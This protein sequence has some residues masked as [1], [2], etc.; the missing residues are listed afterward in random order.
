MGIFLEPI[1]LPD[2]VGTSPEGLTV[3]QM[4]EDAEALAVLAAPCI[5]A[6]DFTQQAAVKA[7]LRGAILRWNDSG[8][9][10]LVSET[11][12]PFG[13]TL[14]TRQ[15]RRTMFWPT[16]IVQLQNLCTSSKGSAFT[17]SLAGSEPSSDWIP[18]AAIPPGTL[19]W[20][21]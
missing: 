13:K 2:S 20:W 15:E 12:G 19:G 4:I 18:P 10:V 17:L 8:S 7:I 21:Q 5:T 6:A 9:G 14:D 1:D 11:T 3:V 16:E